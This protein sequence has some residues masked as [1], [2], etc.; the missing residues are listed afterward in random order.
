MQKYFA[1]KLPGKGDGPSSIRANCLAMDLQASAWQH[2]D[3]EAA[4]F[5]NVVLSRTGCMKL[6]DIWGTSI[7]LLSNC[8]ISAM[9]KS[10][11]PVFIVIFED[12]PQWSLAAIYCHSLHWEDRADRRW[13]IYQKKGETH[14]S[15]CEPP[16][17]Y[18][19]K[20][21]LAV[22]WL[23]GPSAVPHPVPCSASSRSSSG[24]SP[25][26]ASPHSG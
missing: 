17:S 23:P 10:M 21:S 3:V 12:E 25:S 13:S 19:T 26:Q 24:T 2:A 11:R 18:P 1:S 8:H 5:Y 15:P 6:Q 9:S 14:P 20:I 22:A 4:T 16:S 7:M